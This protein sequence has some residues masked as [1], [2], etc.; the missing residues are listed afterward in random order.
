[1]TFGNACQTD[2]LHLQFGQFVMKCAHRC[3]DGSVERSGYVLGKGS[4]LIFPG[5]STAPGLMPQPL[6]VTSA[7]IRQNDRTINRMQTPLY[8]EPVSIM[9]A[10][11]M[12]VKLHFQL[13]VFILMAMAIFGFG[14][15][16]MHRAANHQAHK[17]RL[18]EIYFYD[19]SEHQ[20]SLENFKGKAVLVNLWA[21]WCVPCITELPA[22]D[23]LQKKLPNDK[24]MVVAVS[25][26]KLSLQEVQA[27]LRG[28]GIKNLEVYLDKDRQVPLK[29]TYEGLPTSFL[30][31]Q[32][33]AIVERY[34]GPYDWDRGPILKKI[35]ALLK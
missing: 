3:G 11:S 30:L 13:I 27:F 17:N 8:S 20:V 18:P 26:D 23:R 21:S 7:S 24:F 15:Y 2:I 34:D 4:G 22:L 10:V 33:G 19:K 31:D 16:A 35:K 28:K 12:P 14:D 6:T 25:L 9:E 5:G 29:W 1:M 32:T